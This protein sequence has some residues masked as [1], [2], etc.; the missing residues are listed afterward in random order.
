MQRITKLRICSSI[1][2]ALAVSTVIVT[3][4]AGGGS[5]PVKLAAY[6]TDTS[7]QLSEAT[8]S[9]QTDA[10]L[11]VPDATGAPSDPSTVTIN[12]SGYPSN[13]TSV[14]SAS[15]TH[16]V[17]MTDFFPGD[18]ADAGDTQSVV[19]VRLVGNFAVS[20]QNAPGG[21]PVGPTV[22]TTDGPGIAP[23]GQASGNVMTLTLDSNGDLLDFSVEQVS[24]LTGV[25]TGGGKLPYVYTKPTGGTYSIDPTPPPQ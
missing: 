5:A 2:A 8:S 19:V 18:Q 10:V 25:A 7:T 6:T 20:R 17:A 24:D 1:V 4:S 15:T 11:S 23:A 12:S 13:V 21:P 14:N 3:A 16:D 9:A 22:T